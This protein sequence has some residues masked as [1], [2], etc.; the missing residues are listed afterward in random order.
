MRV[1]LR[2]KQVLG[3]TALVG[4]V[5]VGLSVH[6][7]AEQARVRLEESDARGQLLARAIYQRAFAM[8]PGAPDP[9]AALREDGGVRA[10]LE[11]SIYSKGVTYAAIVDASGTVIAQ[12]PP[13]QISSPMREAVPLLSD[14]TRQGAIAQLREIFFG[15][16]R[17]FEVREDL[18]IGGV[19]AV[20][21]IGVSTLLVRS[22]LQKSLYPVLVTAGYLLIGATLGALLLSQWLLRPIHVLRSGL[23][24][25]ERGEPAAA[26][27]LPQDEFGEMGQEIRAV[28][29]KLLAGREVTGPEAGLDSI[30]EHLADAVG[31]FGPNGDVLFANPA[32]R[33]LLAACEHDGKKPFDALV[34]H[35]HDTRES[36]EPV[37]MSLP[38]GESES[39]TRDWL[40]TAHPVEG[41]DQRLLGVMIVARDVGA[42]GAVESTIKYSRKLAAL[43]RLTSGVAHEVKNP[44]NAMT[45]HLE[46]LKGKLTARARSGE[47]AA[48]GD[49]ALDH[50]A[51]IGNEIKRLDQVVQGF[52]KFMRPE[53][54][55]L[56]PVEVDALLHEIA[57]VVEPD[58][59]STGVRVQVECPASVPDVHGDPGSLRQ[60]LLNLS[61]NA[62]QAMTHG[63]TL[64]LAARAASRRRV[65]I[66]VEDTGAGITPTELPRIFDLYFT[67]KD[68]GSGIGLSMV[69]RT[70][71]MH[72]G[73][74][75]VQSTVGTG[76]RF[77][78]LLPQT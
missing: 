64:R 44:L 47:G 41:P 67:T 6:D 75:E 27:D 42:L 29:E 61:I 38:S 35:T 63:G 73:D 60:V 21:R 33:A 72:D 58:A 2:T 49:P 40:V 50:V 1:S 24:R 66:T 65:E 34:D 22:E 17:T 30:V 32:L 78:I 45:I 9:Y 77:R 76:T 57:K 54:L 59:A 62:C 13:E 71:Q 4:A 74:I 36:A 20:T 5:V 25:L 46:L 55:R 48:P 52:L 3:V 31:I 7:L 56:Q 70:V 12:Y 26:L 23:R 69:Y 11:S 39:G 53:D 19:N 68:G 18:K 37:T 10:I 51:I 16:G 14:F 28:S 8:I 15:D 43:G